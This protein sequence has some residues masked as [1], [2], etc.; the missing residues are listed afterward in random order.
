[1]AKILIIG[2]DGQLGSDLMRVFG[3]AATG[4]THKDIEVIDE[5]Q[6]QAVIENQQPEI[7]V[8]TAAIVKSEWCEQNAGICFKVNAEGAGNVAQAAAVAG[9]AVVF[10][11][12]DYVFDGSKN[13]FEESDLPKPLNVYGASKLAGENFT[14][15]RN[16]QYYL[17][18]SS[19]FFGDRPPHKGLDFPRKILELAKNG[20]EIRMVNDQLGSPTY[21]K[22]LAEKIKELIERRAPYG[23]YHITN[24]GY[25]SWYEFA[26]KILELVGSQARLVPISSAVSLSKIKR[27][28]NS[29]LIN[30][31]IRA[32]GMAPL[33][34]WP[35]A[36][37]EYLNNLGVLRASQT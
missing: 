1:M 31:K 2:A 37:A 17:I 13:G 16:P 23:I 5:R 22:D 20:K 15:S 24:Q 6:S 25:C 11:S 4:L 12:T 9:A 27:P 26:K 36:L 35:E 10:L 19:W 3:N 33:R 8:N 34:P 7:V 32:L 21:T 29:V 30:T 18:R 14:K 28:T